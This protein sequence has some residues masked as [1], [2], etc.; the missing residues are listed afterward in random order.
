MPS[1]II[2]IQKNY[3]MSAANKFLDQQR[4]MVNHLNYYYFTNAFTPEEIQK[5]IEIGVMS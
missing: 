1:P 4:N 5:I 2:K 3:K